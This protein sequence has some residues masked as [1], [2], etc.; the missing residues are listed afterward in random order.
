MENAEDF[1]VLPTDDQGESH[2]QVVDGEFVLPKINSDLRCEL[3]GFSRAHRGPMPNL[4]GSCSLV[5]IE[6]CR[7]ASSEMCDSE[8]CHCAECPPG[9]LENMGLWTITCQML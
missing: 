1:G 5:F 4:P 7:V 8:S 9:Y 3:F 6:V 2:K